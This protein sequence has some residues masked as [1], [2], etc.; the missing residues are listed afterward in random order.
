M[1][2]SNVLHASYMTFWILIN[3]YTIHLNILIINCF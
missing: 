2:E 1:Q 3:V